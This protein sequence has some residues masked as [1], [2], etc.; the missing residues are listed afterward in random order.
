MRT[1]LF[2]WSNF[3]LPNIAELAPSNLTAVAQMPTA[4]KLNWI[5]PSAA[6]FTVTIVNYTVLVQSASPYTNMQINTGSNSTTFVVTG[7][8]P[9]TLYTFSVSATTACSG[10][11]SGP[12]S[13]ALTNVSTAN[14]SMHNNAH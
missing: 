5:A 6:N 13:E 8:V 12:Y 9:C 4:V 11:Y 7:L 10:N 2:F 14:N 3:K 1:Y